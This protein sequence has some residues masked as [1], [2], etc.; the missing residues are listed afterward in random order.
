MTTTAST[1]GSTAAAAKTATTPF[2][3]SLLLNATHEPLAV[4]AARRAVVL[5]LAGKAE[6]VLDR[7]ASAF[8]APGAVFALPAVIRLHRYVRVPMTP[9]TAVSRAGVMRRDRRRCAY[10]RGPAET[11][12]HVMPRSRGGGHTWN[13]CVACCGRC[14]TR[15]ADRLLDE[16]GWRLPFIPGPPRRVAGRLWLVEDTDPVWDPWLGRAA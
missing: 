11:I 13:N 10:C 9:M 7:G 15:K 16:I 2:P 6:S 4:V 3:R 8:H 1:S 14:N 5:V 12:D